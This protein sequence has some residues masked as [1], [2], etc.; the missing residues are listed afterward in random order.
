[1]ESQDLRKEGIV[2]HGAWLSP[3][4]LCVDAWSGSVKGPRNQAENGSLESLVIS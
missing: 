4:H 3:P 1:M 2:L